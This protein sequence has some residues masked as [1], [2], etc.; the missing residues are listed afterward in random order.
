M[1]YS[2]KLA[3]WLSRTGD[4]L[5]AAINPIEDMSHCSILYTFC[6][7]FGRLDRNRCGYINFRSAFN[8]FLVW[9]RVLF[10]NLVHKYLAYR[11]NA[12]PFLAARKVPMRLAKRACESRICTDTSNLFMDADHPG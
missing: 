5:R 1:T 6:A 12:P 7:G 2:K 9:L 10:T 8:G 3:L 4:L 11:S